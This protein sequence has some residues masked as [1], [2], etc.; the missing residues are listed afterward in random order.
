MRYVLLPASGLGICKILDGVQKFMDEKQDEVRDAKRPGLRVKKMVSDALEEQRIAKQAERAK[1]AR[2][3]RA[4][5]RDSEDWPD[6][7]HQKKK[8]EEKDKEKKPKYSV[9]E[10]KL[11]LGKGQ[12]H[13]NSHNQ[14]G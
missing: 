7:R 9:R 5:K 8:K 10:Q 6:E 13:G 3:A 4:R 14:A 11:L 12:G 1:K 2:D